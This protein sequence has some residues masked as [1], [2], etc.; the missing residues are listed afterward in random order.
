MF[1]N[2]NLNKILRSS[3]F[4]ILQS[5]ILYNKASISRTPVIWID[6]LIDIAKTKMLKKDNSFVC[7]LYVFVCKNEFFLNFLFTPNIR[8]YI[9]LG[10]SIYVNYKWLFMVFGRTVN[11]VGHV[12][13]TH[14][15]ICIVFLLSSIYKKKTLDLLKIS[16][17]GFHQIYVF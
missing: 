13:L 17:S 9:E 7:E 2:S 3:R 5:N 1:Q 8:I 11:Y 15:K 14:T 6:I 16:P 4:K 12:Q 10:F